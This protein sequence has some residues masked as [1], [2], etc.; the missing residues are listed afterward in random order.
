M[1]QQM[2]EL[3]MLW[4]TRMKVASRRSS[5][6]GTRLEAFILSPPFSRRTFPHLSMLSVERYLRIVW[7]EVL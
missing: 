1:I 7:M 2:I 6:I 4:L 3:Q 5:A